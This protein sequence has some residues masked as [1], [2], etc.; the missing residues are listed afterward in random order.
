MLDSIK[1]FLNYF[2]GNSQYLDDADNI[3]LLIILI[4]SL[5]LIFSLIKNKTFR[6]VLSLSLSLFFSLQ[7]I[8]LY[9]T[10]SF[11][12]YS[13]F[14]HL[15]LDNKANVSYVIWPIFFTSITVFFT[16]LF[17]LFYSR[18]ILLWIS[19]KVRFVGVY[20]KWVRLGMVFISLTLIFYTINKSSIISDTNTLFS[21]AYSNANPFQETLISLNMTDYVVPEN[22]KSIATKN[23]VV[24]SLESLESSFL[25]EPYKQLTPELSRLKEEWTY[26]PIKQNIGSDWTS[27]SIYT[28]LT[29]IPAFFG[30]QANTIFKSS[31]ESYITSLSTVLSEA[32]YELAYFCGDANFSGIKDMLYTLDFDRV[33][34]YTSV[35]YPVA[36]TP[37]GLH[38]KDVF[39]IAK[40]ELKGLIETKKP[41]GV[42]ISTTDTHFPKGF[43][44]AR[45]EAFVEKRDDP[46]E[47][48]I[49]ATDYHIRDIISFLEK[50]G[51]LENTVVIIVPDH[52]KMGDDQIFD[53]KSE[54]ELYFITNSN[55]LN[56]EK[57]HD[58]KVQLDIPLMI[59]ESLDIETNAKFLSQYITGDKAEFIK[60]N[61]AELT[62]LNTSGLLRAKTNVFELSKIS[63]HYD[64][65]ISDTL[66]FIAHAG[67]MINGKKYTNSLEALNAS[68]NKGF[69]LFELDIIKTSDNHYVA[70]HDWEKW[71]KQVGF[72]GDVPPN[73]K[74]FKEHKIYDSYSPLDM[75]DINKWFLKHP[76]ARLVTDKINEPEKFSSLFIDKSRLMMELFDMKAIKEGLQ[77]DSLSVMPS[78]SVISNLSK[79]EIKKLKEMG[80]SNISVSVDFAKTNSE[81]MSYIKELGVNS[82]LYNVNIES[83]TNEKFVLKYF[84]DN[85]YGLY[86]DDWQF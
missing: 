46:L 83:W 49:S 75:N 82:Y 76:N 59:I 20:I 15:N 53:K 36:S 2:G 48:M 17:L 71:A 5:T 45:M 70:A 33:M 54:R 39:D 21:I 43:Y 61:I 1:N 26:I 10:R 81:M 68:Y 65:Y 37:F 62:A 79:N 25:K 74:E 3:F 77:I 30:V 50:E 12:G 60:N 40:K 66:R 6:L 44:D 7:S 32:D 31:K 55:K 18:N 80:V 11:I 16:S 28:M 72:L 86:S 64:F 24:I 84:M 63:K 42:F 29:G 27:G 85:A 67:G 69:R 13:F 52:L 19:K 47:F 73:L 4:F 35:N 51:V 56:I 57:S 23:L 22:V 78:Q 9:F 14:V 34:D 38:D 41:Y 8:S 58:P